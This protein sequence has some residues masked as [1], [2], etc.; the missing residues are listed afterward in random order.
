MKLFVKIFW[1]LIAAGFVV[2]LTYM[3]LG[4]KEGRRMRELPAGLVKFDVNAEPPRCAS[5]RENMP[6]TRDKEIYSVYIK[7]RK[8]FRSK[9]EYQF[10]KSELE[11]IFDNVKFAATKGDWGAKALLAKFYREGLGPLSNNNVLHQQPEYAVKI[12]REAVEAGQPW[13]YYDL[14]VAYENGEGVEQANSMVAWAYYLKAAKLGSP[15]A[16]MALS[17]AYRDA[18]RRDVAM[19]MMECAYNQGSAAAAYEIAIMKDVVHQFEDAL[20]VYHNGV[21]FGSQLCASALSIIFGKQDY[22]DEK[23]NPLGFAIDV[24]RARRY[25]IIADA[26]TI[27]PDLRFG[28]LDE[29][30]PLPPKPLPEWRGIEAALTPEPEG[31]PTY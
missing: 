23:L 25:A 17:Q 1:P 6:L 14:G 24:E 5:W 29:V 2:F 10:S 20:V 18:G 27:N 15:D 8:F 3:L 26:L 19:N 28:R 30:L 4:V 13:G 7:A 16:Q 11:W 12:A 21:K 9:I 31:P 22:A